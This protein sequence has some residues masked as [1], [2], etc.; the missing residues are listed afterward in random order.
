MKA[1]RKLQI[2]FF[3]LVLTAGL[4]SC[5]D[6]KDDGYSGNNLI[7]ITTE[8]DPVIIESD[9][10]IL[11]ADLTLTR[12]YEKSV[13]FEI[14]VKNLTSDEEDLVTVTPSTVTIEPGKKNV[15]FQIVS[16][17][18]EI[19]K[20]DA[21]LEVSVKSLPESDMEVKQKLTI[22]MKPS[23]RNPELTEVQKTL[24]EGYKAKGLDLS[25]WIGVIPVKVKVVYPGNSNLE[26]L[27]TEFTKNYEGKTVVTLSEKSTEDQ[28][29]LK[30]TENP[31]G[32]TEFLYW[33]LRQETIDN[34]AFWFDEYSSPL[35]AEMMNLIGLSKT[36]Q[37]TFDMA[38]DSIRVMFPQNSKSVIE[39]LGERADTYGDPKIV[40][41]FDYSYTAWDRLKKLIDEGNEKA[42]ECVGYGVTVEPVY[43]LVHF[44]ADVDEW[45]NE[46]SD[47]MEP[48]AELD[49]EN[50]KM[51][52]T[53]CMDHMNAGGY[54][55]VSVEFVLPE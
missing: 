29:M 36:S 51:T 1:I 6:S 47:W 2:S 25:K 46:P 16:S 4:F 23:L 18:K 37:E 3:L 5:S 26:P 12:A 28:P 32:L 52:F 49:L 20:A 50:G 19:L 30:M 48:K 9:A 39:F 54:T 35:Y 55:Q 53:F 14:S 27:V 34:D 33:L 24:L 31:M 10:T 42:I 8:Q 21:L 40:V 13:S 44:A 15:S 38:L 22:R 7:Y 17:Q 41:P 45:A 43:Y 11:T